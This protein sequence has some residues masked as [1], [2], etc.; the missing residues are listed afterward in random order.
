LKL[1]FSL[2]L[3]RHGKKN[4]TS[5]LIYAPAE[6]LLQLTLVHYPEQIY[7]LTNLPF[8]CINSCLVVGSSLTHC[9]D[10]I[11]KN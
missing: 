11:Q 5:E 10:W 4:I 8:L 6:K 7:T 9:E 2:L 1:S 3:V